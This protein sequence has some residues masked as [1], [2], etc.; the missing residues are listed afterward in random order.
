MSIVFQK[1]E[2]LTDKTTIFCPG[3]SHGIIHR[4]VGEVLD[5]LELRETTVGVAPVG[6]AVLLYEY[7]RTDIVEAPHGR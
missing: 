3:C 1:P 4:L 7:F 6:C 5:E 2:S